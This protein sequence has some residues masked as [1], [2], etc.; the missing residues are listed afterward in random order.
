M[1]KKLF[2]LIILLIPV[3]AQQQF[4]RLRLPGG[5]VE[6]TIEKE[7]M[8]FKGIPYAHA[9]RWREPEIV[10]NWSGVVFAHEYGPICPQKGD[11]TIRLGQLLGRYVPEPSEDCLNLNVWV[12]QNNPPPT[13]WPVMVYIHGGSFTGGSGSEPIYNGSSLARRGVIV[14]TIN[15][16]LGALGFL[17]LPALERDSQHGGVG[18]Y[19]LHDQLAAFR[20]VR[21]QIAGFGGNP[22]NITVFGES[23]GSMSICTLLSSNLAKGAFDRAILESGGCNYA[24]AKKDA[25][26][27]AKKMAKK[28]GCP[29]EDLSCW[30][31]LPLQKLVGLTGSNE[32]DF[33]EGPF[34]PV[35]DG[36]LLKDFPERTLASGGGLRVPLIVGANADE[37]QL[38]VTALTDRNKF[39]WDGF[40]RLLNE[41]EPVRADMVYEHYKHRYKN[42]MKAYYAFMTERILLCPTYR[43]GYLLKN[44]TPVYGYTFEYDSPHWYILG[45]AHGFELPFIFDSRHTWPFWELFI[46]DPEFQRTDKL[47]AAMQQ[48]WVSFA[49]GQE[50]RAGMAP[51]PQLGSGW[52]LGFDIN[53]GWRPDFWQE[54]CQLW[55][56]AEYQ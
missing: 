25:Y 39:T 26:E 17:A 37:Y 28:V 3:G 38:D 32:A 2:F 14:V 34:K 53:W 56:A 9:E 20:W 51:M 1:I 21:E 15:Y 52:L 7:I 18:N 8:S 42:A 19:G 16:R 6:G 31:A 4:V 10:N 30:R 43:A 27:Q 29:L 36:Y 47:T 41:K 24:L 50:P 45:S 5:W 49:R 35:V 23:A 13:G 46:T 11:I 12:P 55:G 33:E 44:K 40:R 22:Q 54:R 48:A